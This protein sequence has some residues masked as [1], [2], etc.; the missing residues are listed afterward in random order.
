MSFV[1]VEGSVT[2]TPNPQRFA[3][4]MFSRSPSR[5]PLFHAYLF[6]EPLLPILFC[7][8]LP[9]YGLRLAEGWDRAPPVLSQQSHGRFAARQFM[10]WDAPENPHG[11]S[12]R[13]I[14]FP[15]VFGAPHARFRTLF[16]SLTSLPRWRLLCRGGRTAP[17]GRL[18]PPRLVFLLHGPF[19]DPTGLFLRILAVETVPARRSLPG[20]ACEDTLFVFLFLA[21]VSLNFRAHFVLP[22]RRISP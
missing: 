2:P 15:F 22:G 13:P 10:P 12:L 3:R 20:P 6:S 11:R 5:S 19:R 4:R 9:D 1:S 8:P 21:F 17:W 18:H 7:P 16:G 14:Y